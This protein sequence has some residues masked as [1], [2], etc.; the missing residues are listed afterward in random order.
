[1]NSQQLCWFFP[2]PLAISAQSAVGTRLT[3]AWQLP[4]HAS[5]H[6]TAASTGDCDSAAETQII[7]INKIQ[8]TNTTKG[9]IGRRLQ[10]CRPPAPYRCKYKI[11]IML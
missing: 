4:L 6:H 9:L 3:D 11:Q 8:I 2:V 10:E 1:M 5:V 7:Q